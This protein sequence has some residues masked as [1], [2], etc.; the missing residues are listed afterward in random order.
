VPLHWRRRLARGYDQSA[1]LARGLAARLGLPC[2]TAVLRRIRNTP[3]QTLQTASGRP[4][5]VRGAFRP[6]RPGALQGKA[7]LLMDDVMTTGSTANEAAR[8]LR[9]SGAGR[10]VVAVLARSH[11]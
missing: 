8:A 4:G 2:A 1:A 3:M 11:G 10:V 9:E 6:R 7:V 5:N